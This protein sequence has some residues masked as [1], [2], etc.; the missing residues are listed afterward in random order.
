MSQIEGNTEKKERERERVGEVMKECV[1][2]RKRGRGK[3]RVIVREDLSEEIALIMQT[4]DPLE[5]KAVRAR[6]R[7]REDA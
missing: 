4:V 7:G 3:G 6:I 1:R 2:K 5:R